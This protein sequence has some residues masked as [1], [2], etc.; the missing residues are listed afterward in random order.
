MF[1]SFDFPSIMKE[2]YAKRIEELENETDADSVASRLSLIQN[3]KLLDI[4]SDKDVQTFLLDTVNYF[5][6]RGYEISEHV[7][8]KHLAAMIKMASIGLTENQTS[9][10]ITTISLARLLFD[11]HEL[12]WKRG[13]SPKPAMLAEEFESDSNEEPPTL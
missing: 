12:D 13:L 2:L 11:S 5:R 1:E 10:L 7:L 9:S 6:T 3:I 8:T 4:K